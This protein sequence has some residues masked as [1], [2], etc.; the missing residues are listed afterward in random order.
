MSENPVRPPK[1]LWSQKSDYA[2]LQR[3]L[4]SF[5]VDLDFLEARTTE[6]DKA[7]A[8]A[9]RSEIENVREYLNAKNNIE[10]GWLSL[11]SARRHAL[12]A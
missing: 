5:L 10:G 4:K 8:K 6:S 1:W 9:A 2:R 12:R 11:H 3:E 7:W